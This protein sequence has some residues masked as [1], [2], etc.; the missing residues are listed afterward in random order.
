M[1][2]KPVLFDL[3]ADED[4][5]P[6]PDVGAAAPVPDLASLSDPDPEELPPQ[7]SRFAT[8]PAS[9]LARWFWG[10]VLAL[11]GAMISLAV[12]DFILS[13]MTRLPVLGWAVSAVVVLALVLGV[14]LALRELAALARLRRVDG[15]RAQAAT[16]SQD[17]NLAR[18]YVTRIEVLYGSR[19]DL[20]WQLSRFKERRNEVL[21]ADALLMLTEEELLAPLDAQALQ[22]VEGA[23]RQVATVTALVPMAL[24][25]VVVALLASVRMIRQ[26]AQIYGGRSGL[27][28]SWRLMRAVLAHLTATGAV[29]AGDDLLDSVLGGSV[30]SKLSRRFG[31]GLVNGA[32]S[33]RVGIA[34]MEV[35]R[36]MPFSKPHRPS[37]R[38]VIKGALAGLFRRETTKTVATKERQE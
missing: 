27:F 31:E 34:A 28:S 4:R 16:A 26:V 38:R 35:C 1:S 24:A 30:L 25:D 13:L 2:K 18:D 23:A 21:D 19:P 7:W 10:L 36:P 8:R 15:L 20:A 22:V 14:M 5:A 17:I 32:L 33:A 6:T 29:A 11:M 3:E 37:T 9:P 12:W